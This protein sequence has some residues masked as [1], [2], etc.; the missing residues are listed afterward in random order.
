MPS[1]N[2]INVESGIILGFVSKLHRDKMGRHSHPIHNK[3]YGVM[4]SPSLPKTNYEVYINGLP[5]PS[6]NV[7]HP[8]KHAWL[9]MFYLDLLTIRT[10]G[11]ILFNVFLHSLPPIYLLKIMIHLGET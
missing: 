3:T 2:L 10:L 9:K 11:H 8:I 5:H 6:R 1:H 7:D 4:L